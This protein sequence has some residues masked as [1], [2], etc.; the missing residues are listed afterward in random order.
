MSGTSASTQTNSDTTMP[1]PT[2][3]LPLPIY[4]PSSGGC[5]SSRLVSEV[6]SS[7]N[8]ACVFET[9]H[10]LVVQPFHRRVFAFRRYSIEEDGRLVART[11]SA[12]RDSYVSYISGRAY[13]PTNTVHV[14]HH[15][16]HERPSRPSTVQPNDR[17]VFST[18]QNGPPRKQVDGTTL[19]QLFQQ[20]APLTKDPINFESNAAAICASFDL[21]PATST[22]I[23]TS[24]KQKL[25]ADRTQESEC[26]SKCFSPNL[27]LMPRS[28]PPVTS[29][30]T[31]S[32]IVGPLADALAPI[33]VPVRHQR[34][35]ASGPKGYTIWYT[36]VSSQ[37]LT[38]PPASLPAAAGILYIHGDLGKGT[39]QVWLCSINCS[40]T[41][42]TTAENMKH[43]SI[44]DR[45][46]LLRSDGISSWLT[47]ANYTAIQS[48]KDR[49]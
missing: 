34:P 13:D 11:R 2:D 14:S 32:S 8:S 48:R 9:A 7:T 20:L 44:T 12:G 27:V 24:F 18:S 19:G 45:I 25:P 37:P 40:W 36:T 21:D 16:P 46:L 28:S 29:G 39:K 35:F 41:D 3:T 17:E 49:R 42:I 22:E 30:P 10:Q 4:L 15:R 23:V 5:T 6:S 33:P 1:V 47:V 26:V 38:S 31:T 43:P